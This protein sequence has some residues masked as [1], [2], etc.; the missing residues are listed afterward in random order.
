MVLIIG[1]ILVLAGLS[2]TTVTV[3]RSLRHPG[4]QPSTAA[5]V[6][7]RLIVL[8]TLAALLFSVALAVIPVYA[9]STGSRRTIVNVNGA[10]A[11]FVLLL[12]ALLAAAPLLAR[13]GARQVLLSASFGTLL[14]VFCVLGGFSVGAYYIP[15]AM[16]LLVAA[17][18]ELRAPAPSFDPPRQTTV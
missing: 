3:V 18:V 8:A 7:H 12:P 6:G 5:A 14:A 2:L 9:S 15:A 16:L 10:A 13:G 4:G 1:L 17:A 11:L